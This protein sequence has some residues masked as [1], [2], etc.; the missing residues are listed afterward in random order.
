MLSSTAHIR[1]CIVIVAFGLLVIAGGVGVGHAALAPLTS[2]TSTAPVGAPPTLGVE[3]RVLRFR[4]TARD[5]Q[6]IAAHA[7]ALSLRTVADQARMRQSVAARRI[8]VV[9]ELI[10]ESQGD[11]RRLRAVLQ[12]GLVERYKAGD[13]ADVAFLLSADGVGDLVG[14]AG[15]VGA[16][17]DAQRELVADHRVTVRHLEQLDFLLADI[18]DEQGRRAQQLDQRAERLDAVLAGAER[19]HLEAPVPVGPDDGADGTWYIAD[20]NF[21][22]TAQ[23][24]SSFR[25][26]GGDYSGGTRT[27]HRKATAAQIARVLGDRRIELDTSGYQDISQGRIDGRVLDALSLLADRMRSV[28]VTS[29]MSDH[30]S[31]TSS[32]SISMHAVGCAV[33]IGSVGSTRITGGSQTQGGDVY[34]AVTFLAG[35]RGDLAPHQVISLFSLGGPTLAMGDHDD[36]IHLGYAC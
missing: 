30:P 19:A 3:D 35:L 18:R 15:L 29:L 33:D 23:M 6:A 27:P 5:R 24:Y 25:P 32:G 12:R 28:R 7:R 16:E 9:E 17:R 14:R 8:L 34:E 10:A 2:L 4:L 1:C 36:H 26:S 11:E 13:E 22:P 20:G 31:Y 21:D